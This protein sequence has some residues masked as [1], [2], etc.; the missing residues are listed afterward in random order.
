V[1]LR[2]GELLIMISWTLWGIGYYAYYPFLSIFLV[3]FIPGTYL[4]LFYASLTAAA[5]PL[6]VIGAWLGRVIEA[7]RVMMLGMIISGLG[8]VMLG[9]ASSIYWAL[10]CLI[11]YYFFF[12]SLPNFYAYMSSMGRGTI[13]RV[14]GISILPSIVMPALGGWVANAFTINAVFPLSG[15]AVMMSAVPLIWLRS[16][17]ASDENSGARLLITPLLVI[18]PIALASPYVYLVVKVMYGLD[19]SSIGVIATLAEVI[20][21]LASLLGSRSRGP[22]YLSINLVMFSLIGLLGISYIFAVFYGFWESIIPMSLEG[23]RARSPRDYGIVNS[24]QQLGW[25][26][27]YA[28]SYLINSP[29]MATEAAAV[30]SLILAIA[31]LRRVKA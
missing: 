16:G 12:I 22:L 29:V 21:M 27:G 19:Y 10:L 18:I 17:I 11:L 4:G 30:L 23:I 7:R 8:L 26:I 2:R 25:L 6:P 24:M 13:A 14:W 15:L 3:R 28:A 1:E 20:G 5:L 9:F 31:G